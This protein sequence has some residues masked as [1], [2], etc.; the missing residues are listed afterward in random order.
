[1]CRVVSLE[2][3]QKERMKQGTLNYY[4]KDKYR[5]MILDAAE[6]LWQRMLAITTTTQKRKQLNPT[7][8][9]FFVIVN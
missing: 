4:D 9:L 1:M 3:I 5:E 7:H 6:H 8:S 2:I